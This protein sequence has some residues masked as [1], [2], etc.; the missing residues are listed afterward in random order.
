MPLVKYRVPY[1][2][3]VKAADI[4]SGK[5]STNLYY[6][7]TA[8]ATGSFSYGDGLPGSDTNTLLT[9]VAGSYILNIIPFMNA[10]Y[11]MV[12]FTL[13]SILGKQYRTP[14]NN[15]VALI[16]GAPIEIASMFPHGLTTGDY[17]YV[18][19]VTS[20]PG[21]NGVRKVHVINALR[22]TLDGSNDALGWSNDGEFQSASGAFQFSY[23]DTT[24]V[25]NSTVGGVVGDAMPLFSTASVRRLNAGVGKSFRSRVSLSPLSE[26]DQKDG[27]LVAGTVTAINAGFLAFGSTGFTNGA[28]DITAGLSFHVAVSKK[29][30]VTLPL[31][32]PSDQPWTSGGV[33]F[34]VQPNM[35]SMLRRKPRLTA[36]LV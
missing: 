30:A 13:R 28:T 8:F 25:L 5:T 27:A 3:S 14:F 12:S 17:V 19:G 1:E 4:G 2:L 24:T 9:N 26:A 29:I 35:G 10:N 22:F 21:A 15:I 16:P 11:K 34:R 18:R 7:R 32:F 20:P 6:L 23:G 33:V 31:V 36:P